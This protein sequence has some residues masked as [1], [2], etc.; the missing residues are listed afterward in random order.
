MTV[1]CELAYLHMHVTTN[2][3]DLS[4]FINEIWAALTKC[5]CGQLDLNLTNQNNRHDFLR[6]YLKSE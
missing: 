4:Y 1:A 2:N 5:L 6:S 3:E